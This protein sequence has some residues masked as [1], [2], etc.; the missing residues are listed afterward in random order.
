M[1]VSALKLSLSLTTFNTNSTVKEKFSF[2]F[3]EIKT[4]CL[5][6]WRPGGVGNPTE[7]AVGSIV[8]VVEDM[9]VT[10]EVMEVMEVIQVGEGAKVAR[11]QTL[12][13][14]T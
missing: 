4:S 14:M 5:P 3:S 7:V 11:C 1:L 12:T 2:P 13:L 8:V 6:V 9:E 10:G